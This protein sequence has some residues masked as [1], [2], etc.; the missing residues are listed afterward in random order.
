[1]TQDSLYPKVQSALAQVTARKGQPSESYTEHKQRP[2]PRLADQSLTLPFSV[3]ICNDDDTTISDQY[4][5]IRVPLTVDCLQGLLNV[6]PLQL[7]SYHLAIMNG[8][9]VDFPRNLAK[10]SL[11]VVFLGLV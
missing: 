2:C 1:M 6:L 7:L 9:D 5:T 11:P 8:V 4:R 10:V 3:I